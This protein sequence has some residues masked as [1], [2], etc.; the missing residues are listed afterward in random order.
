M[1]IQKT[2]LHFSLLSPLHFKH[3]ARERE[4]ERELKK[5]RTKEKITFTDHKKE[6]VNLEIG[7]AKTHVNL[8][9]LETC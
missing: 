2:L 1:Q 9:D 4:R 6:A 5:E 3:V 7:A 8:V